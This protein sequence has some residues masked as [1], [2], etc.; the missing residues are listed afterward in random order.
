MKKMFFANLA[1]LLFLTSCEKGIVGQ[2]LGQPTATLTATGAT[3]YY[4]G[5]PVNVGTINPAINDFIGQGIL[6]YPP[7]SYDWVWNPSLNNGY[8]AYVAD[9]PKPSNGMSGGRALVY[10]VDARDGRVK[11]LSARWRNPYVFANDWRAYDTRYTIINPPVM[12][13]WIGGPYDIW[14]DNQG[15]WWIMN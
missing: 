15:E 11:S 14:R 3:I 12:P 6:P 5:T 2:A 9:N 10:Y 1:I 8:G 4:N 7:T 13:G